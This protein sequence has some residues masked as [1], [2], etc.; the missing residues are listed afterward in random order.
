MKKQQEYKHI[1]LLSS[2]ESPVSWEFAQTVDV[3][4]MD[5]YIMFLLLAY[6]FA[7]NDSSARI[8]R[9]TPIAQ[10]ER[11]S[12]TTFDLHFPNLNLLHLCVFCT[13][14]RTSVIH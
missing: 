4:V 7:L 13:H 5:D 11:D 1:H 3:F 14:Y 12:L 10:E 8:A 2:H 9:M 6:T